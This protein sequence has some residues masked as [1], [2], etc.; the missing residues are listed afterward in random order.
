MIY[1][2][3]RDWRIRSY[4]KAEL[5]EKGCHSLAL[6]DLNDVDHFSNYWRPKVIFFDSVGY[7]TDEIKRFLKR[8]QG[9]QFILTEKTLKGEYSKFKYLQRPFTVGNCVELILRCAEQRS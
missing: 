2:I 1:I 9:V 4:L 3:S 8:Y 7:A 5:L 6:E